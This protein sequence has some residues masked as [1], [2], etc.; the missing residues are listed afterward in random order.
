MDAP[1]A[2]ALALL[3]ALAAIAHIA[4]RVVARD[5]PASAAPAERRSSL[6]LGLAHLV[7]LGAVGVVPF[8]G[9]GRLSGG[10]LSRPRS[11]GSG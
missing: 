1:L 7:S 11:G 10:S 9:L 5:A 6:L 4:G 2:A 8:T 3:V